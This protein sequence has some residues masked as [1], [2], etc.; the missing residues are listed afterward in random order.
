VSGSVS[1]RFW[2]KSAVLGVDDVGLLVLQ[3][4]NLALFRLI[5]FGIHAGLR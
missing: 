3:F 4:V 2:R 1:A 5:V